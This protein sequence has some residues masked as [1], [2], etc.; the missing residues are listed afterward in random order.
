MFILNIVAENLPHF[1]RFLGSL[2]LLSLIETSSRTKHFFLFLELENNIFLMV[3]FFKL[4]T[5][6]T[7][8]RGV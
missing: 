3:N 6:H 4:L 2:I 5:L 8:T 1:L 7:N